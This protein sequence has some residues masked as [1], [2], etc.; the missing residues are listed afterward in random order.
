MPKNKKDSKIKERWG[1]ISHL[2]PNNKRII[3][4]ALKEHPVLMI[5]M[6]IVTVA[7][8]IIPFLQSG[9]VAVII[10]KLVGDI[11]GANLF[12]P[13]LILIGISVLPQLLGY[14]Y[15]YFDKRTYLLMMNVFELMFAKKQSELEIKDLEDPS[16]QDTIERARENFYVMNNLLDGQFN[17]L[18]NI[19]GLVVASVVLITF[20]PMIFLV[21]FIGTIPSFW[22]ETRY[23]TGE[24]SIWAAKSEERRRFSDLRRRFMFLSEIIELKIF[25]NANNFVNRMR[26]LL[27]DFEKEQTKNE[28][29]RLIGNL[30]SFTISLISIGFAIFWAIKQVTIGSI[31][32]GTMTFLLYAITN[33]NGSFSAFLLT[34]ASQLK[35]SRYVT[36]ILTVID[37][38]PQNTRTEYK[39]IDPDKTPM[40]VFENIWFKYP[41]TEEYVLK[42]FSLTIEP[43]ERIAIVGVNGSG[44]TTLVKL[45]ARF[46]Q[47]TKGRILI[48]GIDLQDVA[49]DD[50]YE[51]L[52]IL[53]QDYAVYN[54]PVKEGIAL[55]N[56]KKGLNEDKV[57]NAA[58][59]SDS[60]IFIEKWKKQYEQMIGKEFTDGVEPSKGQAQKLALARS[61]YRNP[62]ILILDE[63][64]ASVDA[65]AEAKIFEGLE[66]LHREQTMILISHRFGTVRNA[67]KICVIKDGIISELGTHEELLEERGTYARLFHK[68]AKGYK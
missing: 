46:Y 31:E 23:G 59:L 47:P 40:I 3:G 60:N 63:P 27:G 58:I 35:H 19:V 10:N 25:Q 66:A 1:G 56:S 34:I 41:G 38:V 12:F 13:I 39:K 26:R 7:S 42:D 49:I 9:I 54:F 28:N 21:V 64:T 50:W 53:F 5:L 18:R 24:W 20:S 8:S 61:F 4:I 22:V 52:S 15:S 36:D 16:F 6:A 44:K 11:A 65:E 45:L 33:F 30:I 68:Q 67:D 32:V 62:K 55:G 48:D 29:T 43:N 2:I 17:F 57:K 37:K 51:K 14:I